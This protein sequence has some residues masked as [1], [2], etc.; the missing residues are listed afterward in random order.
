[1]VHY[2]ACLKKARGTNDP[3]CRLLSKSY[4]QC[5]MDH[6]VAVVL[7]INTKAG[8][9]LVFHYPP[10]PRDDLPPTYSTG[11]GAYPDSDSDSSDVEP[12]SS[13]DELGISSGRPGRT[14]RSRNPLETDEHDSADDSR[15]R[16]ARGPAWETLFGFPTSALESILAPGRYLNKKKFEL[17][18]EPLVY[19]SYPVYVRE[20]GFWRK[21][22]ERKE[23][24]EMTGDD[25]EGKAQGATSA[26][27]HAGTNG[28][29]ETNGHAGSIVSEAANGAAAG[30]GTDEGASDEEGRSMKEDDTNA[31]SMY[32][33]ILV[34][35]PPELE[36]SLRVNEMYEH[37]A[38]KL[39]KAL[40]YEQ[41]RSSWVSRE[42]DLILSLKERAKEDGIPMSSLWHSI[43]SRSGLAKALSGVFLSISTSKIAHVFINDRFDVSLQ[44]P[45]LASISVLPSIVE[46]QMPGVWLTTANIYNEE[47]DGVEENTFA[48]YSSLLLLDDVENIVKDID[49]ENGPPPLANSLVKFVNIVKPTMSFLDVSTTHSISLSDIQVLSSHLIFW[50][51]ARAIPP[52]HQRDIYI[53]SPNADMRALPSATEAYAAR[54]PT[55]PSLPKM[56][57]MLA[58]HPRPYRNF[59]PSKDHREAYLDILAW[60]MKG[61]WVT[62]LRTFAW[63]RVSAEVQ[64]AVAREESTKFQLQRQLQ[65]QS[66]VSAS[67]SREGSD[68]PLDNG[69]EPTPTFTT[70]RAL[71]TSTITPTIS[72]SVSASA[73]ASTNTVINPTSTSTSASTPPPSPPLPSATLPS[74]KILH[75]PTKATSSVSAQ[76]AHIARVV[77]ADVPELQ[78]AWPRLL[79]YLNGRHALEKI[80][81]REAMKQKE[82]WRLLGLA[83]QRGALLVTRHW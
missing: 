5:R 21:K 53:V 69:S 72:A 74:A 3:E 75:N 55:L 22:K 71:S 56:L 80:A 57:A 19:V 49:R 40:K 26:D 13:D 76:L 64:A 68:P 33:V 31:M 23:K 42:S 73:S 15:K 70:S 78:E 34:L 51:R 2:L 18:L 30:A 47:D 4:L 39:S 14:R 10:Y 79:K 81:V 61:G 9:R 83:E 1:M 44:I 29:T 67:S 12:V 27:A 17:Y 46:P 82:V 77:F 35:N 50:R 58:G 66:S 32:N 25:A 16:R 60:L 6:L 41:A 24:S 8:P 38:K 62:Q 59:I 28:S 43:L 36:H 48:R 52:L 45:Q 65:A 37:V 20:D 11:K 63:V 7:V 54:F